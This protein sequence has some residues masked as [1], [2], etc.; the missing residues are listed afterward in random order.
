MSA[1]PMGEPRTISESEAAAL[2]LV[3]G[4]G[5]AATGGSAERAGRASSAT[6]ATTA[7]TTAK[8]ALERRRAGAFVAAMRP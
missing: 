5:A 6:T 2:P 3:A 1:V 7:L 8:K 4:L